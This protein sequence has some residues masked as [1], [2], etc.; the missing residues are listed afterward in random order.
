MCRQIQN[1]IQHTHTHTQI[2]RSDTGST[3]QQLK[4]KKP[5]TIH[6]ETHNVRSERA[7]KKYTINIYT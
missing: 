7:S 2:N 5:K 1:K 4:R 6:I 3:T